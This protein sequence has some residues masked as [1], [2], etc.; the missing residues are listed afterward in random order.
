MVQRWRWMANM[1]PRGDGG[2]RLAGLCMA[3]TFVSLA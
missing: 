3:F 1:A 2:M